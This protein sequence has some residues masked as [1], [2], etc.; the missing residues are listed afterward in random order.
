LNMRNR[1]DI[2]WKLKE[3]R[4]NIDR[5]R[6]KMIIPHVKVKSYFGGV[7]A[8]CVTPVNMQFSS[9]KFEGEW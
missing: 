8:W 3:A 5:L 1:N 7:Y 9:S 2:Y 6:I 4:F